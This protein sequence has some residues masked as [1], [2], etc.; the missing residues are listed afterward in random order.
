MK[1]RHLKNLNKSVKINPSFI[2]SP[3]LLIKE[4]GESYTLGTEIEETTPDPLNVTPGS[5]ES[6][7]G[8][9][10]ELKETTGTDDN[11]LVSI[12]PESVVEEVY[13]FES[14]DDPN[15]DP[16]GDPNDDDD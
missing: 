5:N 15:G 8:F 11:P 13:G 2:K 9:G 12:R 14:S 16:N 7:Y 10:E 6:E 1:K 4:S 3:T